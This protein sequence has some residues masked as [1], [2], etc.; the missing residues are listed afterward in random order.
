MP[1]DDTVH[2]DLT[3]EENFVFNARLRLPVE[4]QNETFIGN[5]VAQT[6]L[7]LQIAHVR[8]RVVGSVEKR[9]ISG[10]QRKRVNIGNELV[11]CPTTLFLDEA[12]AGPEN[13]SHSK[14]SAALGS[15]HHQL[16]FGCAMRLSPLRTISK[17]ERQ[18][19]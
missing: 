18:I 7:L 10:G 1:Q 3:V 5:I 14:R 6:L 12:R 15:Q 16:S 19:R 8:N 2:E 4:R 11:M 17:G 9:G 13:G